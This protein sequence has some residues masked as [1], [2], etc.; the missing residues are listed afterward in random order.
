M[1]TPISFLMK[2]ISNKDTSET[3]WLKFMAGMFWYVYKGSAAKGFWGGRFGVNGEDNLW[4]NVSSDVW[5]SKLRDG[6]RLL[7]TM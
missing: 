4:F 7:Y 5:K 3:I 1:E 6:I 2:T